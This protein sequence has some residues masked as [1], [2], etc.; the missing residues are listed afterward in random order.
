M[1][2]PISLTQPSESATG[3]QLPR[4]QNR[5]TVV[6][7][8]R[9]AKEQIGQQQLR[10][11]RNRVNATIQKEPSIVQRIF[12]RFT[13]AKKLTP[14]VENPKIDITTL[15]EI[16]KEIVEALPTVYATQNELSSNKIL[17]LNE[18]R[19]LADKLTKFLAGNVIEKVSRDVLETNLKEINQ[20]I[21]KTEKENRQILYKRIENIWG[22]D[23]AASA[24]YFL[25][26]A[27]P[28]NYT[29]EC[30]KDPR[31]IERQIR[32]MGENGDKE[33]FLISYKE[34]FLNLDI[35]ETE[36]PSEFLANLS[37]LEE[38]Y[39]LTTAKTGKAAHEE[40][41]IQRRTANNNKEKLVRTLNEKKSELASKNNELTRTQGNKKDHELRIKSL[42]DALKPDYDIHA[43]STILSSIDPS[44]PMYRYADTP[45]DTQT[46]EEL[47]YEQNNIYSDQYDQIKRDLDSTQKQIH[48]LET[49]IDRFFNEKETTYLKK[50]HGG[51]EQLEQ[52]IQSIN[53]EIESLKRKHDEQY[54][55]FCS[56]IEADCDYPTT[57]KNISTAEEKRKELTDLLNN[58]KSKLNEYKTLWEKHKILNNEKTNY[59]VK[60]EKIKWIFQL[61]RAHYKWCSLYQEEQSIKKEIRQLTKSISET[62]ENVRDA[63]KRCN[64]LDHV[65]D[66]FESHEYLSTHIR[67]EIEKIREKFDEKI[68]MITKE[69][70]DLTIN[71]ETLPSEI[72]L[73][74]TQLETLNEKFIKSKNEAA[75]RK[76]GP[77][78]TKTRLPPRYVGTQPPHSQKSTNQTAIL[79]SIRKCE[80]EIQKKTEQAKSIDFEIKEKKSILE[81]LKHAIRRPDW[82]PEDRVYTDKTR[83]Q[84]D[85]K[86]L[87]DQLS[88]LLSTHLEQYGDGSPNTKGF[89]EAIDT[90]K[91]ISVVREKLKDAKEKLNGDLKELV[92]LY[93]KHPVYFN[94]PPRAL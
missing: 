23:D 70:A 29:Q 55:N 13:G 83:L 60:L 93:Y 89:E 92:T 63:E 33:D 18:L 71:L 91:Q 57:K 35:L 19:K 36:I 22:S 62:E 73:L 16:Y 27:N 40:L 61:L 84:D 7:T 68:R 51:P 90:R 37:T 47:Y 24:L 26:H 81:T 64:T 56:R 32:D 78:A 2:T 28:K 72:A 77:T 54:D 94:P 10:S 66:F 42:Q 11:N 46:I 30:Y 25:T 75:K 76:Q 50:F 41:K 34:R 43:T 3:R 38:Y 88:N 67:R 48:T 5:G 15:K 82:K 39:K 58:N 12:N 8:V 9:A 86:H 52:E 49:Q 14:S 21:I 69:V 59:N 17:T 4:R 20:C 85:I 44:G 6:K 1:T 79:E 74:K 31:F 53:N 87:E 65:I 80:E 45:K